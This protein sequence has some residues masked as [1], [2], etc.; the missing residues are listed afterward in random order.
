MLKCT[1][2][3]FGWGSAPDSAGGAYSAPPD[4][5]AGFKGLL[6]KGEGR[7]GKGKGGK[8]REREGGEEGKGE[9]GNFQAPPMQI[10]GYATYRQLVN[11]ILGYYVC[12][13]YCFQGEQIFRPGLRLA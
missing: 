11:S 6:L 9:G 5:L 12:I 1:K 10:S 3:D 13:L 4:H 8:G 2:F 7:G